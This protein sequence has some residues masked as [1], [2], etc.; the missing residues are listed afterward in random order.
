M[1]SLYPS[2]K[3][4]MPLPSALKILRI[5]LFA[6]LVNLTSART[7]S[8]ELVFQNP[9][10]VSGTAG[11]N[12]AIYRFPGVINGVDGLVKINARSSS[13]VVLQ[14]IDVDNFGWSKAF[15]PQLGRTGSVSGTN[16]WWMDF[17]IQFVKAGTN[18]SASVSK[19]NITALDVDGDGLTIREYVEFYNHPISCYT[20]FRR[21]QRR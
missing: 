1:K 19:F 6:V 16:T 8:Q 9:V 7:F 17:E 10:L 21:R 14:N 15:Q 4:N 20:S 2:P 12:G 5:L 18:Q 3:V 11:Q 13:S